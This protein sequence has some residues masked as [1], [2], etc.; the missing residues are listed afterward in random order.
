M[1]LINCQTNLDLNWSKNCFV[2]NVANQGAKFSI[3]NTNL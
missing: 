1:P 2:V 3:I